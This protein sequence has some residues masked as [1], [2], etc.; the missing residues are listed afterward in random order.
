MISF[1]NVS[2]SFDGEVIL[3]NFNGDFYDITAIMGP[4]GSGK[5]T[6]LNLI[7]GLINP[8][9]GSIIGNDIPFS[10]MFQD[11]RLLEH[12]D[13][14]GNLRIALGNDFNRSLAEK[15]TGELFPDIDAVLGKKVRDYSGGMKRRLALIRALL[16]NGQ[17]IILD[18]PF[19]GLDRDNKERA[20]ETII[21]YRDSRDII[22]VL[23]SIEDAEFFSANII[24]I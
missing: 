7:L 9:S 13:L 18:E 22:M 16:F 15:I 24:N 5:S 14:F 10:V 11:D 19:S 20:I 6:I 1:K 3:N 17:C 21:K 8:D 2:K 23:H 12:L 4:S